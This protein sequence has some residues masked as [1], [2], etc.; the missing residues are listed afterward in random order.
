MLRCAAAWL[1]NAAIGKLISSAE[2]LKGLND[3]LKQAKGFTQL[4]KLGR[5]AMRKSTNLKV[6]G[7]AVFSL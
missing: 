5:F 6:K 4:L 2:T 3:A 1:S 7:F